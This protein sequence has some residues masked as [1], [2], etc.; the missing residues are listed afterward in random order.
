MSD[1][2][3]AQAPSAGCGT[4]PTGEGAEEQVIID[5][6]ER[7]LEILDA[8][9]EADFGRFGALDWIACIGGFVIL[10][11]LLVWWAA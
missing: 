11:L 5:E 2:T 7:R 1:L 10:P 3:T 4:Q 6:L 9:D 8:A